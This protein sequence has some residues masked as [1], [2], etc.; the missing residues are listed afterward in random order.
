[1]KPI[2]TTNFTTVKDQ[3]VDGVNG[4]V[5]EMNEND[6]AD[7]LEKLIDSTDLR[8]KLSE[9]LSKENLGNEEELEKFYGLIN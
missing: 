7:K 6:I 4:L 5:C 3:I 8:Q 1:M 2:V 9:N